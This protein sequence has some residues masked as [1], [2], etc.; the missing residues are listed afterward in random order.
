[1]QRPFCVIGFTCLAA[2][3][4]A[5]YAG[6]GLCA[7]LSAVFA[8]CAAVVFFGLGFLKYRGAVA[9]AF[10]A[11]AAA[12]AYFCLF[13]GLFYRPAA[14]LSGKE[15]VVSGTVADEPVQGDGYYAYTI[16]ADKITINGAVSPVKTK[17]R[18]YSYSELSADAF[19]R[20]TAE[21]TLT[22]PPV[23]D[24]TG[25]DS[26]SYYKSKGVYLTADIDSGKVEVQKAASHPPYYYAVRLRQYISG[27]IGKYVGGEQGALASG[28][29]IGDTS[30]LSGT[31]T[32]DF[33]S[34]GISHILA[35]SGTQTSLIM[36]YLMLLFSFLR[37]PRRAAAG[38]SAAAVFA[39][40][41]VTGFSSSVMRAGIMAI[42]CLGAIILRRDADVLNSLGFAALVL[43]L[44]NP[45]AATDVGLL[46]SLCATLGMALI[47][48]P[49]LRSAKKLALRLPEGARSPAGGALSVLSE[50]VGASVL[51]LPVIVLFFGRVSLTTLP[52]N[53]V[54]VPISLFVTLA[55]AVLAVLFPAKFLVFLIKPLAVLIRLACAFMMWFAHL[56]AVVPY[57]SV[58]AVYGFVD[59]FVVYAVALFILYFAFRGRGADVGV[60][61]SCGCLALAVGIFSCA[62]AD[63]GVMTVVTFPDG[64]TVITSNGRAV[65]FDLAGKKSPGEVADYLSERNINAVDAVV[66]ARYDSARA[67]ALAGLEE[68][69]KVKRVYAPQ[70]GGSVTDTGLAPPDRIAVPSRL[71]APY[72][73]SLTLLPD[74][75]GDELLAL[76]SCAGEKAVVAG[77]GGTGDYSAYNPA[78]L[79]ADLLVFGGELG[80]LADEVQPVR[81]EAAPG[82]PPDDVAQLVSSG[83]EVDSGEHA[84]LTRG[85]GF[86]CE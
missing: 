18:L 34:D 20:V 7:A 11:A 22:A 64:G 57:A 12:F 52:A 48:K 44:A 78:A 83:A 38:V 79:K 59:I 33:R 10:L 14:A 13:E 76:V 66:L 41:A 16:K 30:G 85:S 63:R 31:V 9:A 55:A 61:V 15:A 5:S 25:Y 65:V 71:D 26:R 35:V 6:F 29:L 53:M 40:M 82:A 42:L 2:L 17:I 69:V 1:M 84:Y 73:V 23:N 51:T 54:E 4:A 67:Q 45:Y 80:G 68:S 19:D 58:S 46:L 62:V 72:G 36:E 81:A 28:I 70:N 74:K 27:A 3:A 50:T 24:G 75:T 77:E 49:L 39:F 56:L 86:L 60:L 37:L 21:V 47:S 32:D 8:G 43:C